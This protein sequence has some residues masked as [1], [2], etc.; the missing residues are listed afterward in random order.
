M[1]DTPNCGKRRGHLFVV[2]SLPDSLSGRT[3]ADADGNGVVF[4]AKNPLV[5][6]RRAGGGGEEAAAH[7][8]STKSRR[9]GASRIAPD[10]DRQIES[11]VV[12]PSVRLNQLSM[13]MNMTMRKRQSKLSE[14]T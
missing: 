2:V 9:R 12:R 10:I 13:L 14:R 1:S 11:R 7:V 5:I 8:S 4:Q 3:D 6:N